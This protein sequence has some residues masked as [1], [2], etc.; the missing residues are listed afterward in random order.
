MDSSRALILVAAMYSKELE[1]V[2]IGMS[3]AVFANSFENSYIIPPDELPTAHVVLAGIVNG[4]M[5]TFA[6]P[7]RMHPNHLP[8][9]Q[10]Y[11]FPCHDYSFLKTATDIGE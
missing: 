1:R 9:G 11:L 3:D 2:W 7:L 6:C 10:G 8:T 5:W 4:T